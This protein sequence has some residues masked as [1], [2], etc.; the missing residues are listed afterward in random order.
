MVVTD[1]RRDWFNANYLIS[2]AI[3]IFCLPLFIGVFSSIK[4]AI[5]SIN[6]FYLDEFFMMADRTLHFNIDPWKVTFAIFGSPLGTVFINFFYNLWFFIMYAYTLWLMINVSYGRKRLQ[7]LVAFILSW[8]IVG[9]FLAILFSSAGPVYYGR[10]VG[11]HSVYAPLMDSLY[12]FNEEFSE[13]WFKVFALNTQETLW[14]NYLKQDVNIGSGI[15]AM[16]SMHL[17]ISTLLYLSARQ[18]NSVFAYLMLTFLIIIL[19]GSVH[20]GWHYA[21]DGYA[22]I[23]ITCLIWKMSGKIARRVYNS[24]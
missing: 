2:F 3:P 10:V 17:S 16:P 8:A 1:F 19:I 12:A 14:E 18:L 6:P 4:S 5:S 23:L 22:G 9:S 7:Y 11:D 24:D 13:S 20:L 21:I 15:S